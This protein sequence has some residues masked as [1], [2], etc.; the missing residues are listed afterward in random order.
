MQ[1]ITEFD[2]QSGVERGRLAEARSLFERHFGAV[3]DRRLLV[4]VAPGRSEIAGNHTDHEGGHVIAGA[5]DVSVVAIASPNGTDVIRIAD[6]DYP[7]FEVSLENLEMR[8]DERVSSAALVRGMALELAATGRLP[9]GFDLASVST[10]PSGGGLS[11]SAAVE[12]LYGRVMEA[13]WDAPGTEPL[14]PVELAMMSKRTE[15]GYFGKPCGL[16]DQLSVCLG[17]LAYM[18]FEDPEVST[19]AKL[20]FD[21]EA[22]GYDLVLVDVG[23][24]HASFTADYAA[25]PVEMQAVARE[26]GHERLCEVPRASFDAN[27]SRIRERLG[28][29][30]LVRAIH[31]WYENDLVDRRW[32]ALN[33]GDIDAFLRLT[34]ESGAS[35]GMFLQNV[36]TGGDFQPAMAALGLA[37]HVLDGAGAIRIHG[38]G[39]GGSIQCFVPLA[40]LD[41]F[42]ERMDGWLGRGSCRHYHIAEE[43]ARAAWL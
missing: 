13:L 33:A 14:S 41:G 18:G 5:L 34:R 38:G 39:F 20:D 30:A 35:S 31:Y 24:D 17:G 7:P 11:S 27:V 6:A 15:N 2:T 16:M 19:V 32:E 12:A 29:R 3:S 36:S 43:G 9:A 25:V 10:I 1:D 37:E 26:L 8:E 42:T 40:R 4:A 28:D 22:A 23:C 21:F